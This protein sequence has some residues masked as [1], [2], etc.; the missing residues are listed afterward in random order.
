MRF[1]SLTLT[2]TLFLASLFSLAAGKANCTGQDSIPDLVEATLEQLGSVKV[3][4]WLT[5]RTLP[6]PAH[7]SSEKRFASAHPKRE[8]GVITFVSKSASLSVT[9]LP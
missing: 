6:G 2:P 8:G 7:V 4:L 1:T 5:S 3:L 9:S